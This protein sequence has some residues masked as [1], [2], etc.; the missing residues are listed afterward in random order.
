M[1]KK[2]ISQNLPALLISLKLWD[3]LQWI[4]T[5][6][7]ELNLLWLIVFSFEILKLGLGEYIPQY[8]I[9]FRTLGQKNLQI[10]N[11]SIQIDIFQGQFLL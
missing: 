4:L 8:K 11:Q 2:S 7:Y 6:L 9:L 3:I 10:L 5:Q 1:E